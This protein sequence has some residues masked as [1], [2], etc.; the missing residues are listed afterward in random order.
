MTYFQKPYEILYST[1]L[2]FQIKNWKIAEL[3]VHDVKFYFIFANS[4]L[5]PIIYGYCTET[6][7]K[8]FRI[9]FTCFF[10][11]KVHFCQQPS[12]MSNA[13]RML[14]MLDLISL[15]HLAGL[16]VVRYETKAKNSLRI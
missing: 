13:S 15:A 2:F 9:T 5:N 11:D 14:R 10:K 7:R 3:I 12:A 16:R 1:V 6:M 4:A 8:A